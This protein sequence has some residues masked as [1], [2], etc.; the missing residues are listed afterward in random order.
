MRIYS[1][2]IFAALLL[3]PVLAHATPDDD[4]KKCKEQCP[5][6]DLAC[7]HPLR[8]PPRRAP[9]PCTP[10]CDQSGQWCVS[11]ASAECMDIDGPGMSLSLCGDTLS[12][13]TDDGDCGESSG[14]SWCR[15]DEGHADIDVCILTLVDYAC[16]GC[17]S[18]WGGYDHCS[19]EDGEGE[20]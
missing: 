18:G 14:H 17:I 12:W 2:I 10:Y 9:D 5:L 11:C 19:G 3:G 7:K 16:C 1:H 6:C 8:L 4:Y 15:D 13:C 20:E